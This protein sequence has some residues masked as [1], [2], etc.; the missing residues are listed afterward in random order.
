MTL[1][2]R[3]KRAEQRLLRHLTEEG[4]EAWAEFSRTVRARYT[5]EECRD[6]AQAFRF[7]AGGAEKPEESAFKLAASVWL[8]LSQSTRDRLLVW[9]RSMV[10]LGQAKREDLVD[11]GGPVLN[12]EGVPEEA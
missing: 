9:F 1:T 5:Q 8:N 10:L 3:S 7:L 4:R 6:I 11:F 2:A 12:E